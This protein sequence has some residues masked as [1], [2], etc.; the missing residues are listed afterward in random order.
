MKRLD[1]C[2]VIV[3]LLAAAAGCKG[4]PTADLRTGVRSLALNPDVMFSDAGTTKAFDVEARDQQL[5][6]I[7]TEITVTSTNPAIATVKPDSTVPSADGA[8]FNF[9]VTAIAPGQT[10]LVATAS[11]VSDTASVTVR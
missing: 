9:I 7:A 8:H 10:K 11:G 3:V 6:P 2:S 1:S 4:D 5:N